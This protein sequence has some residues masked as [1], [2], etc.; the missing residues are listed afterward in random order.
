MTL[1]HH[2]NQQPTTN[3]KRT[4][5]KFLQYITNEAVLHEL[6]KNFAREIGELPKKEYHSKSE[7]F[8][9]VL[10]A[11]SDRIDQIADSE[12]GELT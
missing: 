6:R 4:T 7:Y 10:D 12:K 3:D 9:K 5:M 11:I 1:Q 2:N 8:D